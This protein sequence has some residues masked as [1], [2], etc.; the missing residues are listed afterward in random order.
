[1]YLSSPCLH[2]HPVMSDSWWPHGLEPTRFFCPWSSPGTNTGVGCHWHRVNLCWIGW[3]MKRPFPMIPWCCNL[4]YLSLPLNKGSTFVHN[5]LINSLIKQHWITQ[6]KSLHFV[7]SNNFLCSNNSL[8]HSFVTFI[9]WL[10]LFR[11]NS[12]VFY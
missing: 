2:V 1:M 5:L 9:F 10:W 6:D 3:M 7:S 12:Y 4:V 11:C 8:S